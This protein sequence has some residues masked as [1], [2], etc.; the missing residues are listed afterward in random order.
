MTAS[1]FCLSNY[2]RLLSVSLTVTLV[3]LENVWNAVNCQPRVRVNYLSITFL[4]E[5]C[6]SRSS[7]VSELR[8]GHPCFIPTTYFPFRSSFS[9]LL[10]FLPKL[11][12]HFSR[13]SRV[14]LFSCTVAVHVQPMKR[15]SGSSS[16]APRI[17]NLGTGWRW[18]AKFPPRSLYARGRKGGWGGSQSWPGRFEGD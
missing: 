11:C 6:A 9:V 14:L 2:N 4:E 12:M 10:V 15:C 7:D 5:T 17:L 13:I 8:C 16:A 1:Y 3:S 18:V